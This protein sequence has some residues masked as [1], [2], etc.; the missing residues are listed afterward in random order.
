MEFSLTLKVRLTET[1]LTG[2]QGGRFLKETPLL[3]FSKWRIQAGSAFKSDTQDRLF[4]FAAAWRYRPLKAHLLKKLSVLSVIQLSPSYPA[5]LDAF[6]CAFNLSGLLNL[7][8]M[9]HQRLIQK[10]KIKEE[11]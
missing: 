9:H 7:Q 4:Y 2:P 5:C 3:P 11:K 10:A 6:V 1:H 8:V